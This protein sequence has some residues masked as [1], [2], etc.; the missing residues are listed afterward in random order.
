MVRDGHII[1]VDQPTEWVSSMVV[2]ARKDKIRICIDPSNLN[3]SI[4]R[5]HHPMR[6]I[7]EVIS[8]TPGAKVLDA[9]S[10]FLQ[11]EL[12]E[13]SSFLTTF[14]TPIGRFRWLRLPFR[15]KCAPEIFQ[16][17]MDQMLEG[18]NGAA[19][20]MDDILIAAPTMEEHDAILRKVVE[21]AT[22]Y[23]LKLNFEK[24]HM[25]Q[26]A[27]PYIGHLITADGLK[28]DPAKTEAA[29]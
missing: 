22:S 3:K 9:K 1:Q 11:I 4:K 6:T 26:S 20:V 10:G 16:R 15:I 2:V 18:I 29:E 19:G 8:T 28:P 12:D 24:C 27:V 25:R 14:N 7:E 5:E 23:N 13:A 17:I 21:R